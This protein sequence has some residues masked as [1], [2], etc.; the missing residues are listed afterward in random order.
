MNEP[1]NFCVWPCDDPAGFARDS[2]W[3][4]SPPP[5]LRTERPSIPGF[6]PDFQPTSAPSVQRRYAHGSKKGLPGRDL[7]NPR[8]QIDNAAGSLS[9]HTA[10]TDLIHN[11]GLAE[12]DTHNL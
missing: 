7:I 1:S 6:P 10:D 8:Y 5:P 11:N 12:Y 3:I 9:N 2:G 4:N